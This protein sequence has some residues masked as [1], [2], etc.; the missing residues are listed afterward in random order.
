MSTL[1]LRNVCKIYPG[2]VYAVKDFS[3]D[4][5]DG[6]FIIFVGPSGCGKSTTLRMI[7]GL[8]EISE[9]ELW[10]DGELMNYVEPKERNLSMV[11]QNYALYPNMTVYDNIAY[12]LKIR[13]VPKAEIDRQVK[14]VA[15]VLGL[16]KLLK[17]RP[18]A[19][20]GG[21][22]QRV[23]IGSAIVRNPKILL[24]DEPLSNLDAK[25]RAQMRVELGRLH[26]R[27]GATMIY[28][29][30]DQTE[31]MTL[32]TRIVV[33]KEG[34]IQQVD[35]PQVLYDHPVNLFVAGFIGSPAMNF[36]DAAV[37]AN[38]DGHT[39][40]VLGNNG[41]SVSVQ[42]GKEDAAILTGRKDGSYSNVTVGIRPEDIYTEED[43]KLRNGKLRTN[44]KGIP[45]CVTT[46][47]ML[48]VETMLFFQLA[49]KQ[50]CARVAPENEVHTGDTIRIYFDQDKMH[51]F[52]TDTG[53]T[54]K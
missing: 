23:A 11:F 16:E 53:L 12:S 21:Q 41:S 37:R 35:E 28:V 18:A 8:E 31:A 7:A 25:L 45:V 17:R 13:K 33:M 44:G 4:I 3:M 1:A 36:A 40:L 52:D 48:G 51:L 15:N 39:E 19:L 50:F 42:L 49:G 47:E 30:H 34:V 10:I 6:D 38:A 24:M 54:L 32:G 46:I 5:N 26:E 27:L 20:S 22:K 9:G 14:E 2:D 43:I 29:T